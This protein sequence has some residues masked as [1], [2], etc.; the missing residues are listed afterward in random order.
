M[1]SSSSE[2]R[3]LSAWKSI[4]QSLLDLHQVNG[5]NDNYQSMLGAKWLEFKESIACT[6]Y[7]A[8]KYK[9]KFLSIFA[10]YIFVRQ[11]ILTWLSI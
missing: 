7:P 2:L 6:K 3:N 5:T 8:K 10:L 4:N 1:A 11:I 9:I